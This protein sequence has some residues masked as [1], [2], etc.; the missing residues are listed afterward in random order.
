MCYF[1]RVSRSSYYEWL[2]P[3]NIDRKKEDQ[4]L[5]DMI[6]QILAES[7][8]TY[9]SR[10]IK[11]KLA[12]LGKTVSRRRIARLMKAAQL[13]CKTKRKF[14]I[15]TNSNHDKPISPNLLQRQ[16]KVLKPNQFW[17]GDITYI[18]TSKGWLY[19]ATVI[20]LYSRQVVGW[21]MSSRMQAN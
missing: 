21:S 10:R 16:F 6:K 3:S 15:T 1:L 19:L 9:G 8:K 4:E 18:P 5:T 13:Y 7:R 14:R 20:D 2:N 17:V 12:Q 11:R